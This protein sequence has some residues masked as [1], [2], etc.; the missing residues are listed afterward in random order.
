M[1]ASTNEVME[2]YNRCRYIGGFLDTFYEL[3]L[4]KS[5]EIPPMFAKTD[6]TSQKLMLRQALLEMICFERDIPGV[7]EEIRRLGKRHQ[8]LGCTP[9]AYEMWVD[10]LCEA[11]EIHDPKYTAD[12]GQ[13]WRRVANKT[14]QEM[15]S[16][17]TS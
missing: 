13:C 16:A 6:F 5:P 10:A 12:L 2:S 1:T 11:V 14:I 4:A 17:Y 9:E 3:F 15:L 7:H 8:E